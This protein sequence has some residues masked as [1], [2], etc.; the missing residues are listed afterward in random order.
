MG[1]CM[2]ELFEQMLCSSCANNPTVKNPIKMVDII[3]E[4]NEGVEVTNCHVCTMI[5]NFLKH[6]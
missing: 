6:T 5:R 4:V 1:V 3:I 2:L